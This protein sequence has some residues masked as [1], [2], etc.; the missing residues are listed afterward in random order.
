MPNPNSDKLLTGAHALLRGLKA[1]GAWIHAPCDMAT[2]L[3]S[4]IRE[5]EESATALAAARDTSTM[6]TNRLTIADRALKAWLTKARLVVMLARG[7]RW[8][9]SWVHT[10]FTDSKTKV[11]KRIAER[12]SLARALVTFFA[13]HPELGVPF[14]EVTAARGRAICERAAQSSEMLDLAKKDHSV[15]NQQRQLAEADLRSAVRKSVEW[16]KTRLDAADNRWSDFGMVASV[17]SS[18]SR[19]RLGRRP[20]RAIRFSHS[21]SGGH[22][23]AAA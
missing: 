15:M 14:A 18:R 13:R 11:P 10:G 1:H 6:A 3:E 2:T 23:V 9:E 12:I 4:K 5:I 20:L 16:L 19:T 21:D 22:Q 17:R 7:V 8:S